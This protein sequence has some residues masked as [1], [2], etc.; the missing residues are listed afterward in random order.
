[1]ECIKA[2]GIP[3]STEVAKFMPH[4]EN[5]G[6]CVIATLKGVKLL[7]LDKELLKC[8]LHRFRSKEQLVYSK[9][10]IGSYGLTTLYSLYI[11]DDMSWGVFALNQQI[12]LECAELHDLPLKI[13]NTNIDQFVK[14][15]INLNVCTG[16]RD[17]EDVLNRRVDFKDPFP[18]VDG[19][20][21]AWVESSKG[22][23]KLI[24]NEFDT[25]R[26]ID[27]SVLVNG[28]TCCNS[29]KS[30]KKH[31]LIF[32]DRTVDLQ[33]SLLKSSDS[34]HVN[35]RYLTID[36][37]ESRAQT[38][39]SSKK[40]AIAK[41][42][43]YSNVINKMVLEDGVSVSSGQHSL[44]K[45]VISENMPSFNEGTPQWL[46]W[47]QQAEQA[48]KSSKAMR[49][50]PLIIRWCLSIYHTS[51]AA[52]RQLA[53]K[54]NKLIVLPHVNTLKKYINFTEP[55]TGFNPDILERLIEDSKILEI[56]DFKKNVS[57]IYDEIKIKSGLVFKRS[58]GKLVGFTEMGE[59]NEEIREFQSSC[60]DENSKAERPF[61]SYVN[62]FMVRGICSNLCY[63]FGYHASLGFT[64]S[65]LV[66]LVWEAN[67]ILE[68]IGFKVRAWVCD[69]ASP[70]RKCFKINSV[71]ADGNWMWS[72]FDPQRKVF[73]MSDVPHLLKTTR[74]NIEN[75]HA[76]LDSRNL[77][78]SFV[79]YISAQ[80]KKDSYL[81]IS[82]HLIFYMAIFNI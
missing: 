66:P 22:K 72:L 61:A 70:N 34:S 78:V 54:G 29:C 25:I 45:D 3:S 8:G 63:T 24:K 16:N 11:N 59:I 39:A 57:L 7:N 42:A 28:D 80:C 49:W 76:N 18:S 43:R 81:H 53:S 10:I 71:G 50:H 51:P 44:F 17:F 36:E 48:S 27:C 19:G 60:D 47:Q 77:H 68:C 65:Q 41:V 62:V 4:D 33:K 64:A 21:A 73:F 1:M 75:S 6:I 38:L 13:D 9:Q 74:N 82:L 26:S 55:T 37:M 31:L 46:L 32:R 79:F 69:G 23:T 40:S 56:D 2:G 35:F 15:F 30:Y 12:N 20:S 14:K 5:C 67:H 58:T 52:Y